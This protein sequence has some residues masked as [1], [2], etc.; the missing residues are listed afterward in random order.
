[1]GIPKK[2]I[3]FQGFRGRSNLLQW[4]PTFSRVFKM[5]IS[6]GT[7]ITCDFPGVSGPPILLWIRTCTVIVSYLMSTVDL[8]FQGILLDIGYLE[9]LTIYISSRTKT[10]I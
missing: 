1:M 3:I 10:S 5:L 4:G 7:R 6:I 8:I 2:T 9:K